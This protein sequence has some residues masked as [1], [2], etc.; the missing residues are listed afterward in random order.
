MR[1][2]R[3]S[4]QWNKTFGDEVAEESLRSVVPSASEK[5]DPVSAKVISTFA[6]SFPDFINLVEE[7]YNQLDERATTAQRSLEL[8]SAELSEANSRL[9]RLNQTFDAVLNSLGQAFVVFDAEGNGLDV[10]S[11][12]CESL[13]E[14]TPNG[15]KI[16]EILKVPNEKIEAFMD[17]YNLLFKELLDFEDVVPLGPKTYS[18]S[19]D[20]VIQLDFKPIRSSSGSIDNI[21]MIATDLTKE[22]QAIEKAKQM[23]GYANLVTSILKNKERFVQFVSDF[24]KGMNASQT[25]IQGNNQQNEAYSSIKSILHGLKGACGLFGIV[26][27]EQKI[28]YVESKLI[29]N[30]SQQFDVRLLH[31]DIKD[32]GQTFENVLMENSD[33]VG[34]LIR[35]IEPIRNIPLQKLKSFESLLS[36]LGGNGQALRQEFADLFI[37]K[38]ISEQFQPLNMTLQKDSA[39]LKKK[40]NSIHFQGVDLLLTPEKYQN[41][42]SHLIHVFRNMIDHGIEAPEARVAAGKP[43]EGNIF[44]KVNESEDGL[45]TTIEISD[46]GAGINEEKLAQKVKDAGHSFKSRE[47]L[48]DKIFTQDIST[49]DRVSEISGRGIGLFAMRDEVAKKGGTVKVSSKAGKGTTFTIILPKME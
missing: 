21:L 25:V 2:K 48:L 14:T 10:Y 15:R 8:S 39:R 32:I 12:A 41:F 38:S 44:V 27:V 34:D 47:D 16:T 5:L 4:R 31:D 6:E 49:A 19:K 26:A 22:V 3:V 17:W 7:M 33:V 43:E 24:R 30:Q 46:D 18:H 20:L 42:F 13:L 37:K 1:S 28:H 23:Q 35:N 29:E 11:R 36:K 45:S 9:F 40:V